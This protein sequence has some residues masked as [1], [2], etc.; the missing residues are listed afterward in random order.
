MNLAIF[1]LTAALAI[2]VIGFL[3]ALLARRLTEQSGDGATL[4]IANCFAGGVFLAAGLI[5]VL[6][7]AQSQLASVFPSMDYPLFG[8][9]AT[10]SLA[11]KVLI[12]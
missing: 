12:E 4:S 1:K 5:H 10:A 9:F 3:G 7:D 6:P 11:L 8:L 2:F